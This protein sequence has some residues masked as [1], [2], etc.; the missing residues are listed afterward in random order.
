M[1]RIILEDLKQWLTENSYTRQEELILGNCDAHRRA[2]MGTLL[3]IAAA[4]A[5][6]DY[7]ARGLTYETLYAMHQAFLLSR[8]TLKI[9]RHPMAG[10]RL[11][12]TTWE[13]GTKGVHLQRNYEME[14]AQGCVCVSGK[15][16]WILVDPEDRKILRPS[17]FTAKAFTVCPKEIDCPKCGKILLP[18]QGLEDLGTHRVRYSELDGNGHMHSG[19]Y[20]NLI[21]DHLPS[22]LQYAPVRLFSINYS[23][24]AVGGE[25]LA[26]Y[27]FREGHTYRMEGLAGGERCFTCACEF[28]EEIGPEPV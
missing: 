19:H 10:E 28:E 27:G 23:K 25:E 24:E 6:L 7:D 20:G 1:R 14:D 2:R 15:S 5:G 16:D 13:D 21:W 17:A 12:V 26:L 3:G 11:T 22:E 4:V 8:L 9:H 18:A